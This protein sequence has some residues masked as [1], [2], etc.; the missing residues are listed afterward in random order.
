M[1]HCQRDGE[2]STNALTLVRVLSYG[3]VQTAARMPDAK[4]RARVGT[5]RYGKV[6]SGTERTLRPYL[7]QAVGQAEVPRAKAQPYTLAWAGLLVSKKYLRKA[8]LL[9]INNV[10]EHLR[11]LSQRRY[12]HW[13]EYSWQFA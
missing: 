7:S 8:M 1:R 12:A 4:T 3:D 10:V 11:V 2:Y 13:T 9:R 6:R 5:Y